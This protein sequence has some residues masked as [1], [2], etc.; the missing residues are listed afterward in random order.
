MDILLL[1]Q[2]SSKLSIK[3]YHEDII[4]LLSNESNIPYTVSKGSQLVQLLIILLPKYHFEEASTLTSTYCDKQGCGSTGVDLLPEHYIA[5]D[6]QHP[7]AAAKL[8]DTSNKLFDDDPVQYNVI[9]SS[10]SFFTTETISIPVRGT[11]PTQGLGLSPCNQF[12][13]TVIIKFIHPGQSPRNI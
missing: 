12:K 13:N 9:C 7:A 11:H 10:Y 5:D 2:I 8:S 4:V 1:V 6:S 3:I